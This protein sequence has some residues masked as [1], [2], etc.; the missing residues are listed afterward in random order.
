M[1]KMY[2]IDTAKGSKWGRGWILLP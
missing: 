2:L 1:Q